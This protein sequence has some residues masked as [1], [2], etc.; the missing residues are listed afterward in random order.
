MKIRI[1]AA[2][3]LGSLLTAGFENRALAQTRPCPTGSPSTIAA[4]ATTVCAGTLVTFTVTS[5]GGGI[6]LGVPVTYIWS[7]NGLS[8][9]TASTYS[10]STLS[11]HDQVRCIVSATPDPLCASVHNTS[12]TITMTVQAPSVPSAPSGS[13]TVCPG[14]TTTYGALATNVTSYNWSVSPSNAGTVSGTG[15]TGTVT[16]STG[17]TGAATVSVSATG[18]NMTSA[19]ASTNVTVAGYV[20]IPFSPSGSSTLCQGGTATYTT[21]ANN[22][23]SYTW[24]L[25]G[26]LI[27][28][29][30]AS[31]TITLPSGLTGGATLGVSA[32]GCGATATVAIKPIT[33]TPNV[34]IAGTPAGN[35]AICQGSV[36][37]AYSINAVANATGYTWSLS[38][39]GAGSIS[40][41]GTAATVTWNA[42]YSGLA[43]LGVATSGCNASGTPTTLAVTVTGTVG[44]ATPPSGPSVNN[45]GNGAATYTTSAANALSYTWSVTPATVGSIAGTGATATVIWNS[46]YT[47]NAAIHVVANGCNGPSAMA[48]TTV[49]VY[50]PLKGGTITPS[51]ATIATGTSPG[52][53]TADAASGGNCGG[54]YTYQW[55]QSTDGST[56]SA[57]PG[58][59][60]I[61]TYTPGNLSVTT[62]YRLRVICGTDTTYTNIA[63]ITIGTIP[64][65]V[66]MNYIRTRDIT[67]P[68]VTDVVTAGQLTDPNDVKQTTVY[69]DGLGRPVQ[70]V[71]RQASPLGKDMVSIQVYD[72]FGR[73]GT[74]YLPYTAASN[75]GNYKP[76]YLAE[77]GSFNT[78]QFSGEQ[79]YYGQTDF[80]ASPLNRPLNSYAPGASWVGAGH[81]VS[82]QYLVNT[83]TDSVQIWNI[84]LAPGSLPVSAGGYLAGQLYKNLTTDEQNHQV[85]EY[86]D[87][88]GHVVLKKVQLADVVNLGMAHTGWLCTYYVYDDLDNLRF[89][90]S[91]RAVELINTTAVNWVVSQPIADELCFRY[92]YDFRNRM[93]IKKVPGAG[94][95]WMVY[96]ARDRMI[97]SQDSVFRSTHIWEVTKYDNLNRPDSMGLLT[98]VN[99]RVYHQNLA[100]NS[101]N[102]PVTSG[103]NFAYQTRTFYDDYSWMPGVTSLSQ[104]L[105]TRYTS[106]ANYF[107]TSY[108]AGP[109][110]AVPILQNPVSRG[111]VTGTITK[112]YGASFYIYS[113]SFYD[114]HGRLI[115]TMANNRSN[116][117]DTTT[118]QY[119]FSGKPLRTLVNHANLNNTAQYHKMLTKINYDAGARL[120]SVWKN[121]D[122][123]ATDQR[124]DSLQYDEL[125]QLKKKYLGNMLDSL[126]YAYN[127]RG[128]LKSINKSFLDATTTAPLNYFGME[129][130]YDNS[131]AAG[132]GT[133]YKGLQYNGNIAGTIWKSA[134]DGVNR[135]YDFSYNNAN[136]LTQADFKQ[137]FPGG[138]GKTDP[139]HPGI[140]MDFSTSNLNYDANGNI[141]TMSQQGFK[142][143]GSVVIDSLAYGYLSN[144]NKLNQVMDAVNDTAST[145]GDFHYKGT[146]GTYDYTYDGNGNLTRDLNKGITFISSPYH[147]LVGAVGFGHKGLIQF[148]FDANGNRVQKITW[149]SV[150]KHTTVTNYMGGFVYQ[151][152]DTI[153]NSGL[154][155]DTL[156]YI[157]TEEGRV[158]RAFHKYTNGTTG[159]G[160]EYDFLEKDHLG[161]TRVVLSQEKD[162][163]QYTAT[164]E[165]VNRA[166]ENALFYN[167]PNTVKARTSVSGY[168]VD[169]SMSKP[170]D[171]VAVVNGNGNKQGPAIILKVMTGDSV[172]ILAQ[173]YYNS[174]GI[175]S[176]SAIHV[177]DV[178]GSLATGVFS[179][180]GG[181]HGSLAQLGATTSPLAA[182]LNSFINTNNPIP[183]GKPNAYLNWIL[184]DNQFNMVS[185]YPQSG[186]IPVGAA[187]TVSGK[188]QTPLAYKGIPITKSG[189][190]YIYVSNAT[191]G[192]DVFFDNL[193]VTTHSGPMLEENHYYPYGLTMAGISDKAL[194]TQY[195][196]NKYRYNGKELQ[197]QE[198]S[199]G[200]GLEEYDYGARMQDPQLGRWWAIDPKA[201]QMRR[202]SPYNYAYDNPIRFIDPDGMGPE[203]WIRYTDANGDKHVEWNETVHDQAQ[204]V[205]DYGKDAVDIGKEG[206]QENGYIN[207]SDKRTTYKLNS[208]GTAT[209]LTDGKSSTTKDTGEKEPGAK[210][211]KAGGKGEGENKG[212]E[213]A[214]KVNDAVSVSTDLTVNGTIGAQ[215][216]ANAAS[217]TSSEIINLGEKTLMKG[218]TVE[219]AGRALGIAGAAYS[220]YKFYKEPNYDHGID[221]AVG[222][223]TVAVP[224]VGWA[225]GASYFLGNMVWK[226]ATGK[227]IGESIDE[228]LK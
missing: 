74:K 173:Y 60:N 144:S 185:S 170:N 152:T 76:N 120:T 9:G 94:E 110:Y 40:G 81:S 220:A 33:I 101:T 68:A 65:S 109:S 8:V 176:D 70:T 100:I 179:L 187:G 208:D 174:A 196:Q 151:Y 21:S 5:K 47:G 202:F 217:G 228:A 71:G 223:A 150:S 155:K 107:I 171:S 41:S 211:E 102:Y 42:G 39:S 49:Q 191:K 184:L 26:T 78:A 147:N 79:F 207:E 30:G 54:L 36:P 201:D 87:K 160:Y 126:T 117:I 31:N 200:S 205:K 69:Y 37:G 183:S 175:V 99:D 91:P 24:T 153:Y 124:I 64:G 226:G 116:G 97:M 32:N 2:L 161:N 43:T 219:V 186:A 146:K 222:I 82:N 190:L 136:R 85:V 162:T 6:T 98:D 216:L 129:L 135:Q 57:A 131:T 138:W 103:S 225:I 13:T 212:L 169:T 92:E 88:E 95:V 77:Q 125:G 62:Y 148:V 164:M 168:P 128:W 203:D 18:C 45:S 61:Q 112:I 50:A 134:G 140:S 53:L 154:Y 52:L 3:L 22:A 29:T 14:N 127:I 1:F 177:G 209:P 139:A 80:E 72:P 86:K 23:S 181:G 111:M 122:S 51:S 105:A 206:T 75:D 20:S 121:I 38:P 113:V 195:V 165:G 172:D 123:A 166:T 137:Q 204:A 28:G 188:L 132:S 48:T 27:A 17:Y 19:A 227:S 115:Q 12:N 15:T 93:I 145:L 198:F 7:V 55:Q 197:N 10:S 180:T 119:D 83:A 159:Y 104:S 118:T 158:R 59:N 11:N 34:G 67:K 96:D 130:G 35:N 192:W 194:K 63:V 210:G 143:G 178:L 157:T 108:N 106:N 189:Y 114:D 224:G 73:E 66:D 16:W 156:Q 4:S 193:T 218:V 58:V 90:L 215:K 25:N 56:F 214:S 221:L 149:D 182:A 84:N 44:A 199:D 142:L 133:A 167:I 46:S 213:L 141:L 89:V 163:A